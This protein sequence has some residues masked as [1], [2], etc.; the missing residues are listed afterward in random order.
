[1]RVNQAP[2]GC[3]LPPILSCAVHR[4][5][6]VSALTAP[7]VYRRDNGSAGGWPSARCNEWVTHYLAAVLLP[8][9]QAA[10]R[11][12]D[13][14]L[15][16]PTQVTH[17]V[18][19]W[20]QPLFQPI[21]Q[22]SLQVASWPPVAS[23]A[24]TAIATV[25]VWRRYP[26]EARQPRASTQSSSACYSASSAGLASGWVHSVR[27]PICWRFQARSLPFLRP[28]PQSFAVTLW[29]AVAPPMLPSPPAAPAEARIR[30][31]ITVQ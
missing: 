4:T 18:Q 7:A 13:I 26:S 27:L 9:Q 6:P 22:S 14:D 23:F 19:R 1:M 28:M 8:V 12:S 30:A 10:Q 16:Q 11:L 20:K 24:R 15:L 29:P 21:Q 5:L 3:A 2:R 25:A 31:V 17:A